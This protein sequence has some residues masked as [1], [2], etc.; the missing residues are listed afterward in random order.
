MSKI[1]KTAIERHLGTRRAA[2]NNSNKSQLKKI[3]KLKKLPPKPQVP[4]SDFYMLVNGKWVHKGCGCRLCGSILA[5][6]VVLDKHRYI[7]K[8]LNKKEED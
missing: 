1:K 4:L 7:C 2:I 6:P 8:V 3:S 5:D